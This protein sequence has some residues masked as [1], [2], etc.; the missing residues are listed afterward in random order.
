VIG[1]L[2]A[3][4]RQDGVEMKKKQAECL[5]KL[6]EVGLE[7]GLCTHIFNPPLHTRG[8][9]SFPIRGTG[10]RSPPRSS[11]GSSIGVLGRFEDCMFCMLLS[12]CLRLFPSYLQ[13]PLMD[14]V[15][16]PETMFPSYL[17]Y[18]LMDFRQ[19]FVVTGASWYKGELITFGVKVTVKQ[20]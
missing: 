9:L 1:S 5:K 4:Y 11:P 20:V 16:V 3:D 12:V 8:C 7:S 18:P 14:S 6:G 15:C 19:T 13:Y 2:F 10:H 17:Q